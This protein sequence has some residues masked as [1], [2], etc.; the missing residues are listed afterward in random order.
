[1]PRIRRG[2]DAHRDG[3]VN[4]VDGDDSD[5]DDADHDD[6]HDGDADAT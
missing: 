2:G 5:D 3:D 1:M 4:R 6:D